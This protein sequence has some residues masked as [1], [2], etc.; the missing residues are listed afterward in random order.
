MKTEIAI[1]R[2]I[3]ETIFSQI[4]GGRFLIMTGAKV[5]AI[6]PNGIAFSLPN[7]SWYVK[8]GINRFE[9]SLLPSDTYEMRGY[10][11]RQKECELKTNVSGVYCDQ[12]EEIFTVMTGLNTRL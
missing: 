5:L 10:K 2:E 1:S 12:L 11:C 9:I 6:I 8:D 4:G 3:A 7:D